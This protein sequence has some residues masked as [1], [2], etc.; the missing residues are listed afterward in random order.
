MSV[1]IPESGI[2]LLLVVSS[3]IYLRTDFS[4]FILYLCV[5]VYVSTLGLIFLSLIY[6]ATFGLFLW[7]LRLG[8]MLDL[9]G[10]MIF[11][12]AILQFSVVMYP[13][14]SY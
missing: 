11:G 6:L 9:A 13:S 14:F 8:I 1:S 4:V 2:S 5:F 10:I 7:R 12:N 3:S